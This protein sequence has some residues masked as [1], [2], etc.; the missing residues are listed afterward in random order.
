MI[1]TN[2]YKLKFVDVLLTNLQNQQMLIMS[3]LI[4][5]TNYWSLVKDIASAM[6]RMT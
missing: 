5:H 2:P 6:T 1:K 3:R 4:H